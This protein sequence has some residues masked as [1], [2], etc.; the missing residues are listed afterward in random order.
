[1]YALRSWAKGINSGKDYGRA[2]L[3]LAY[4][5][6]NHPSRFRS[7]G[8]VPLIAKEVERSEPYGIVHSFSQKYP[9]DSHTYTHPDQ[10]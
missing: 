8:I 4:V 2:A 9:I 5:D 3:G 7:P 6:E 1:M 10:G